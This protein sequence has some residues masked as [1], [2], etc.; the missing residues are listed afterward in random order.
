MTTS[1]TADFVRRLTAPQPAVLAQLHHPDDITTRIPGGAYNVDV[2][3]AGMVRLDVALQFVQERGR[4]TAYVNSLCHNGIRS[5]GGS[6]ARGRQ[7]DSAP[8]L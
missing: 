4:R 5:T 6:G 8:R 3:I 1:R 2:R 7:F